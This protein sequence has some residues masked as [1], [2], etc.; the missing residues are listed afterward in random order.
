[1]FDVLLLLACR[2]RDALHEALVL[3]LVATIGD[4]ISLNL[5]SAQTHPDF[6]EMGS[7]AVSPDF[8]KTA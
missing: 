8:G 2:D 3:V 4:A 5:H 6:G 1:V 7:N